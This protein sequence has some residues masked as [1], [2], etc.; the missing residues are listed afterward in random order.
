MLHPYG[1]QTRRAQVL[2]RRDERGHVE[3]NRPLPAT[4]I[5]P[6][7]AGQERIEMLELDVSDLTLEE[8][9]ID[10][11]AVHHDERPRPRG[12]GHGHPKRHE[13][14]PAQDVPTPLGPLVSDGPSAQVHGQESELRPAH[15]T[16]LVAR[17]EDAF[18]ADPLRI[19]SEE[20]GKSAWRN[21]CPWGRT[22]LLARPGPAHQ[23]RPRIG[24]SFPRDP[25]F[26]N[27]EPLARAR[28]PDRG[29]R[30]APLAPVGRRLALLLAAREGRA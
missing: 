24:R 25:A 27:P 21:G 26:Q 2:R 17:I 15:G 1:E 18:S 10:V 22:R 16:P 3:G 14:R 8:Q 11:G 29:D 30:G 23:A 28:R 6:G 13:E 7:H 12:R 4:V 20:I 9:R 5:V 19:F